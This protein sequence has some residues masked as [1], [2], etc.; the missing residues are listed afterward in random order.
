MQLGLWPPDGNGSGAGPGSLADRLRSLGLPPVERIETHRNA[1]VM[2]TWVPGRILRIHE[3]YAH[4]PD[5]V[6]GAVVRFLSPRTGRAARLE[7]RRELLSF[8]AD[9]YAPSARPASRRAERE[10]PGDRILL[11]RLRRLHAVLNRQHFHGMLSAI[12][13][14]LSSRMRTR[15]GE[16]RLDRSTGRATWI[17]LSRRHL[18]RDPWAEVAETLLHEMVHQWQAETGQP[19]DH[20]EAFRRKAR[21]VGIAP[22]AVR[23]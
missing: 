19:V 14:R 9:Q 3:G 16:V 2:L 8:P 18:R 17:A 6:L 1:T 12:P 4:A 10:R 21:A 7:A 22:R 23:R 15:L 20:G 11:D 13:I 5:R